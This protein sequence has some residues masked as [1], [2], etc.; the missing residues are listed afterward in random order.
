MNEILKNALS[1]SP[2]PYI[3]GDGRFMEGAV[4][5]QPTICLACPSKDCLLKSSIQKSG[6]CSRG[7]SFWKLDFLDE[8]AVINGVLIK[9]KHGKLPKKMRNQL[10][11]NLIL[12]EQLKN[13]E[14]SIKKFIEEAN[15]YCLEEITKS[16]STLHDV[17]TSISLILRNTEVIVSHQKGET[18]DEKIENSSDEM[19]KLF[20]AV[21]LL[22]KRLKTMPYISNPQSISYGRKTPMSIYPI[23]YKLHKL[24]QEEASTKNISIKL[25]GNSYTEPLL[26]ESFDILPLVLIDNAIK[27]SLENQQVKIIFTEEQGHI[28]VEVVSYGPIVPEESREKIFDKFYRCENAKKFAAQGSGL[29]LYLARQIAKA[30]GFS[31]EYSV[32]D[33]GQMLEGVTIGENHFTFLI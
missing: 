28:I 2:F 33:K 1:L 14:E 18:Y 23:I 9:G 17:N 21:S 30:N 6:V 32:V 4:M 5:K 7:L 11:E 20:K 13:W 3:V 27:Y 22:Q 25:E 19:K 29:G 31:I 15:N 26:Y 10:K 12:E 8:V 16:V 24:F